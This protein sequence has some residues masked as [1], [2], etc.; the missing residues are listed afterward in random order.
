MTLPTRTHADASAEL[1]E[2]I[3]WYESKRPGLGRDLLEDLA[4]AI[5]RAAQ[6]PDAGR[7]IAADLKTRRLLL[8]RFPY[9]LVY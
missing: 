3:R 4:S 8:S 5:D 7:S 6:N 1:A 9:Q 2:A